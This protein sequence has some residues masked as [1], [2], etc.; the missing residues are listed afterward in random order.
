LDLGRSVR[1]I[2]LTSGTLSPMASFSSELGVKFSIQLEA[3]HVIGKS[4]VR[5]QTVPVD[6][7][8]HLANV[9]SV[10]YDHG[11]DVCMQCTVLMCDFISSIAEQY[12]ADSILAT[13]IIS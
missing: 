8:I 5:M 4:Q 11:A 12:F 7:S 1:T 2:V 3:N 9:H 6:S 10:P 13:N